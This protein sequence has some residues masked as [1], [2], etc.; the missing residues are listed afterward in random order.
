MMKNDEWGAMAYLSHSKYGNK[1][2]ER[3]NNSSL[4]TGYG[5]VHAATTGY[6]STSISTNE[7][8]TSESV[9]K[10]WN[11]TTGYKASTTGN[12]YGIYDTSGGA[13]EYVMGVKADSSGNPYSGQKASANSGFNGT[14]GA[15]GEGEDTSLTG[16]TSFPNSKNYNLYNGT[17]FDNACGGTKC[18]GDATR[19]TRSWYSDYYSFVSA[20]YPWVVRGGGYIGGASAGVFGVDSSYGSASYIY[21]FRVVVR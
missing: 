20:S 4:K 5:A 21:S 9:T 14:F 12:I 19:E 6:S 11:T 16:G 13:W 7:F 10:P 3:N 18:Y 1:E 15:P 8:G 2:I 17:S